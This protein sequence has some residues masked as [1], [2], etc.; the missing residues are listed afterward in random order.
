METKRVKNEKSK[1]RFES[2]V[3]GNVATETSRFILRSA[4][5]VIEL[6]YNI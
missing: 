6:E 3:Y 5:E 2:L 1:R 4:K